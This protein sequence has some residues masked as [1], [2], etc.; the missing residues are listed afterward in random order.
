V[1]DVFLAEDV[2]GFFAVEV[3]VDDF[4]V[5]EPPDVFVLWVV[6]DEVS[7]EPEA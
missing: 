6:G 2:A 5:D 3:E 1:A 4:L 7:E